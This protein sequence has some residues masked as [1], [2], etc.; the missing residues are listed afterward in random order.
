MQNG[1][2]P[3]NIVSNKYDS[4]LDFHVTMYDNLPYQRDADYCNIEK[5]ALYSGRVIKYYLCV[6]QPERVP[7]DN[8]DDQIEQI[9]ESVL[10]EE[11]KRL[12]ERKTEV[13]KITG[14][15]EVTQEQIQTLLDENG[16]AFSEGEAGRDK[17]DAVEETVNAF[18]DVEDW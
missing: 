2:Q 1:P 16:N 14:E 6:N 13:V 15:D 5:V 9:L 3:T 7:I 8:K 10:A 11:R 17:M 18:S 4:F 12:A